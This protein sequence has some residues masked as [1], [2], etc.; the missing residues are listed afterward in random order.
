MFSGRCIQAVSVPESGGIERV[1]RRLSQLWRSRERPGIFV[2]GS[3][4]IFNRGDKISDTQ[5][6][7]APDALVG[8]FSKPAHDQV[9][10]T[11]IGWHIVNNKPRTFPDPLDERKR[12]TFGQIW[13]G[14]FNSAGAEG[15]SSASDVLLRT[16]KC[17][18]FQAHSNCWRQHE[19]QCLERTV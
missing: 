13:S 11:A 1:W 17:K 15:Q 14:P 4:E 10:P 12:H 19:K 18:V 2:P 3:Q 7:T 8:Q 16:L 6:R 9:Q 5:K